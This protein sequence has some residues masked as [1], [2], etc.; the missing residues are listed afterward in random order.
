MKNLRVIF[1]MWQGGNQVEYKQGAEFLAL[2]APETGENTET[3][4]VPVHEP[5]ADSKVEDGITGRGALE[6]E[7]SAAQSIIT[8]H[9]PD[10]LCVLG[11]DCLVDLVPFAWLSEKYQDGFGILWL[12]THPDV[13][14]PAQYPNAHAHVLGALTGNGDPMLTCRVK[15]IVPESKVMIAG[16][17]SPNAYEHGY[18]EKSEINLVSPEEMMTG[19]QPL[20]EWI[21]NEKITHLAIH[22]DLDI[23]DPNNFYSLNFNN[24]EK[25]DKD[26]EGI[27]QGKLK[28]DDVI[29]WIAVA[30]EQSNVVGVGI[31]EYLPWDAIRLKEALSKIPLLTA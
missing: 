23:L 4:T 14:T 31:T 12:D 19:T 1:P 27:A 29:K 25:T 10:T 30:S 15:K 9:A 7:L 26:F 6:A 13:M 16:I 5:S 18:L 11:G 28:L 24:P 2:I 3:V 21:K 17:H 22:F 8:E 20:T